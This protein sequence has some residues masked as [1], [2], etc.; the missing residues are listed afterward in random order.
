MVRTADDAPSTASC[1][2]T[3]GTTAARRPPSPWSSPAASRSSWRCVG[4]TIRCSLSR[5][6]YYSRYRFAD[7]FVDL[8]RA[9]DA[10]VRAHRRDPG[11]RAVETRVVFD[12]D[13]RRPGLAE[14]ATGRLVSIPERIARR[15]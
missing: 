2:A 10:L 6:D 13:A 8:K 3:S 14:P 7:V 9:P 11:R 1:C 5:D 4:A 15:P 12:V